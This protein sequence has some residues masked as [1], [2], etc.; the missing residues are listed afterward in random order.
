MTWAKI[1]LADSDA[2]SITINPANNQII[3]AYCNYTPLNPQGLYKSIDGGNV[4]NKINSWSG[5]TIKSLEIDPNNSQTI[6]IG[7]WA[8]GV[9][10]SVDGGG[11][12]SAVNTGLTNLNLRSLAIDPADTQVIYAG[13]SAGVFKT[14]DGGA[15]WTPINSGLEELNINSRSIRSIAIDPTDSQII[16]IG[17]G[18]GIYKSIDGGGAWSDANTGLGYQY[19]MSLAIDPVS[20]LTI[21]AGTSAGVFKSIDGAGSWTAVNSGLGDLWVQE[22]VVNPSATQTVYAG[23]SDGAFGSIDGGCTW[24]SINTGLGNLYI[25]DIAVD[26][27]DPQTIYA[28]TTYNIYKSIDGGGT[29]VR[30]LDDV[31]TRTLAIDPSNSQTV[32]AGATDTI[33]KTTDGGAI[34]VR[35]GPI[36]IFGANSLAIDPT[37]TQIVY[38]ATDNDLFKS[39]DGGDWWD[40]LPIDTFSG[41]DQFQSIAIDPTDPQII[42]VG[43]GYNDASVYKSLDRGANWFLSAFMPAAVLSIVMDPTN[44]QTIYAAGGDDSGTGYVYKSTDGGNFWSPSF[45]VSFAVFSLVIDPANTQT[46]YIGTDVGVW[47]SSDG[48]DMWDMFS[49]GLGN[50]NVRSLAVGSPVSQTVYAGTS[51][52]SIWRL[53]QSDCTA[54]PQAAFYSNLPRAYVGQPVYFMDM[55][56]GVF[57]SWLWDF[58]DGTKSIEQNPSHTFY[59]RGTYDVCLTVSGTCTSDTTCIS[60]P[61]EIECLPETPPPAAIFTPSATEASVGETISFTNQSTGIIDTFTWNFGDTP[62]A[63]TEENPTHS[64]AEPGIYFVCLEVVGPCGNDFQCME[65]IIQPACVTPVASFT[66]SSTEALVGEAIIFT[67]TSSGTIDTW[68]WDF[69][70]GSMS[71]E[72]NPMHAYLSAGIYNACLT[73]AASCGSDTSC[74]SITVEALCVT[75]VASFTADLPVTVVGEMIH[76]TDTS[77]GTI[78]S[79]LWDFGDGTTSSQ[80]NP[81]HIYDSPG[82]YNVCLTAS[83]PCGTDTICAPM[84]I[85]VPCFTPQAYFTPSLKRA[86]VGET[87]SFTNVS[88]GT[89]DTWNW[90]FGDGTTSTDQNPSHA[91]LLPGT[92]EVCL[93][94]V[95]PCGA[96]T[97]CGDI[98]IAPRLGLTCVANAT[99]IARGEKL[100]Y[101]VTGTN[102]TD[103]PVTVQYWTIATLPNGQ[104]YPSPGA[105]YGPVT[106]TLAPFEIRIAHLVQSV[107]ST[108]PIGTYTYRCYIGQYPDV[109]EDEC[110]FT[111]QVTRW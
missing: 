27:I 15:S 14:V 53:D 81:A 93:S 49:T 18:H 8:G 98:T 58:G 85:E 33:Y 37:N 44:S 51:D 67:D 73:V 45:Y 109:I 50:L 4:W 25:N 79:W 62:E 97:V 46:L 13:T 17:T 110:E 19:I 89:I 26:P 16:Y 30:Q 42:Y 36:Y 63:I 84:L 59:Y 91:Y 20:T 88:K 102:Y 64:Y 60:F 24:S 43:T 7:I 90:D 34:W 52:G 1:G 22:V 47:K 56:T 48:G 32:Y 9:F 2:T 87:I 70:D 69:G 66:P 10:K 78:D 86:F 29:W 107:P 99:S 23:T 108:A 28:G 38:A 35:S 94:A 31:Q 76:F 80:Q 21:Y 39:T 57:D 82:L 55:S 5:N 77:T 92:Y 95:G 101:T 71:A 54:P 96:N 106:L 41:N 3:Y 75:P 105:L 103:V 11:S 61:V 12:W 74:V 104:P 72:Q 111:I 65:I 6:Y 68:Q 83:G 100:R 40:W